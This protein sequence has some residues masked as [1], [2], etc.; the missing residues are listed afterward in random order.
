MRWYLVPSRLAAMFPTSSPLCFRNCQAQGTMLHVWWECPRIR[1]F[2]NRILCLIRKVT[3]VPVVKSPHIALLG[4]D[5]P[6]VS[7]SIQKL[8]AFMLIG[9]KTTLAA[10][11]KQPR[12][13]F[14][15]AKGKISWIM[16]QEKMVSSI[17]NTSDIFEAIWEPWARH[18]GV[19]LSPGHAPSP[20]GT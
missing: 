14:L 8:I 16:T 1:G 10:A 2:W 4:Y 20:S 6:R 19:S 3:G 7:K 5:I 13:S 12:V 9:A 18:V 11:W 15:V 17:S